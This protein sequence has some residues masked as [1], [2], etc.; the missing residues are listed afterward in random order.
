M[1][2]LRKAKPT[3]KN[4]YFNPE[5]T[6]E[7]FKLSLTEELLWCDVLLI[8]DLIDVNI[9][10]IKLALRILMTASSLKPE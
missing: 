10:K 2:S 9:V 8:L 4:M 1:R 5:R 7:R 3:K 6:I